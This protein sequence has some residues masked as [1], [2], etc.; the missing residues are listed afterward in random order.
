MH[1]KELWVL[2]M[3]RSGA[4]IIGRFTESQKLNISAF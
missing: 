1:G 3:S 2:N 4:R